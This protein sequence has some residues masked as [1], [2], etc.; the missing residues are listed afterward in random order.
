MDVCFREAGVPGD[1][2]EPTTASEPVV[3]NIHEL[4]VSV[5]VR[6]NCTVV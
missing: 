2:I 1:L 5:E 6:I 3:H 4:R